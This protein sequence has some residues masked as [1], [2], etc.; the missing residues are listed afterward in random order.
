MTKSIQKNYQVDR[1]KMSN[2]KIKKKLG[3][4]GSQTQNSVEV[5]DTKVYRRSATLKIVLL[6]KF[7]ARSRVI[8]NVQ[9]V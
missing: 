1:K 6:N 4:R 8:F 2:F 9:P 5:Q 7:F 3:K